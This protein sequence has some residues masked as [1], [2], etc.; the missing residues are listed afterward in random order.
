MN[1]KKISDLV[2]ENKYQK[3]P[4]LELCRL[5]LTANDL[6]SDL[7]D[8]KHLLRLNLSHNKLKE[9]PGG[10][11]QLTEI[12]NLN[13]CFNELNNLPYQ[14]ER[15]VN[16]Q[17]IACCGN[18]FT[19]VPKCV[20]SMGDV[21]V[22]DFSLN[23]IKRFPD[24]NFV[25]DFLTALYLSDNAIELVSNEILQF[26]SLEILVLRDNKITH[27]HHSIGQLTKLHTLLLQGNQLKY[28]PPSIAKCRLHLSTSKLLLAGNPLIPEMVDMLKNHSVS[29]LIKW[30]VFLLE[31]APRVN[32]VVT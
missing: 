1:A 20:G 24:I 6:P 32:R 16:V 23:G 10:L 11:G 9:L 29:T 28:L 25:G 19:E 26:H 8:C 18:K 22:I 5:S 21:R 3:T 13:L 14:A 12:R 15:L 27:I 2:L 7:W 17:T 30:Q 31:F 4:E